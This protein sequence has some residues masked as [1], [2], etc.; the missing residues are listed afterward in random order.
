MKAKLLDIVHILVQEISYITIPTLLKNLTEIRVSYICEF[1]ASPSFS[2]REWQSGQVH[3]KGFRKLHIV[4]NATTR[5]EL[6]LQNLQQIKHLFT[7]DIH[8]SWGLHFYT[9]ERVSVS[10]ESMIHRI[11]RVRIVT[12][13]LEYLRALHLS[14]IGWYLDAILAQYVVVQ[15]EV[16]V[17]KSYVYMMYIILYSKI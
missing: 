4:I 9:S 8:E 10:D 7:R 15:E 11:V 17:A 6:E 13:I 5:G 1:N 2:R 3:D 16:S 14:A 12:I